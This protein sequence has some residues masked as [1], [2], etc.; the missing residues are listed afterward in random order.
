VKQGGHG[1]QVINDDNS[2]PHIGGQMP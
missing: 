1:P 2:S